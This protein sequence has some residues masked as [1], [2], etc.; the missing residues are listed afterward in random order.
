MKRLLF[1]VLIFLTAC[2]SAAGPQSSAPSS[3]AG[4]SPTPAPTLPPPFLSETSTSEQIQKAMLESATRWQSLRMDGLIRF[5]EPGGLVMQSIREQVLIDQRDFHFR[6]MVGVADGTIGTL[7]VSDGVNIHDA[8]LKTGELVTTQFSEGARV[9][10]FVPQLQAGTASPNPIW[11]QIGTQLSQLAFPSDLAQGQGEFKSSGIDFVA[12]RRSLVVEW[13]LA[14][15]SLPSFK[16]W[17]DTSTGVILKLQEFGKEGGSTVIGERI[18]RSIYYNETFE[19]S[20]FEKPS[21]N[22]VAAMPTPFG[23]DPLVAASQN[24]DPGDLYFFL[25]PRQA[26]QSVKLVRVSA[27]CIVNPSACPPVEEV[28]VPFPFNFSLSPLSWSP[29]GKLAAFA[30]SDNSAG[31]PTRMWLFNPDENTWTSVAEFPFI[32]PPFWSRD[33]KWIAFRVQDGLG[34]ESA[35]I[36]QRDGTEI[37]QISAGLPQ[38]GGPYVLDGWYTENVIMRSGL[39]G[40]QGGVY[41][42][43]AAT[44]KATLMF[45]TMQNKAALVSSPDASLLAYDEYNA[46]LQKHELKIMEPDGANAVVLASY[47]GGNLYPFVWS[48]DSRLIAYN[49]STLSA[50]GQPTSEVLIVSR[51]GKSLTSVYKGRTVGRLLFSPNGQYLLVEETDSPTGSLLYIVDLATMQQKALEVP[52]LSSTDYTWY[53]PSWRP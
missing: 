37:K 16:A 6:V 21:V 23:S 13:T 51:D 45:Q 46:D 38:E 40:S 53:A 30:Y 49:Y 12:D 20:L 43:R 32:D 11:G 47:T 52:G 35:Y 33:S 28:S 2:S 1:L 48:P 4:A 18:I 10:G 5:Y 50:D 27:V 25:Q 39:P 14:G 17:L 9:G 7:K 42:I 22:P 24:D 26:G 15:N 41:F 3:S 36:V 31:T 29:D 44:G 19:A 34:G 8:N